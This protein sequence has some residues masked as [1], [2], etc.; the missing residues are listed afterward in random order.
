MPRRRLTVRDRAERAGGRLVAML[1]P[2]AVRRLAGPPIVR[3]GL[4]LDPQIQLV[5]KAFERAGIGAWSTLGPE[6]ARTEVR[7]TAMLS[8]LPIPEVR[9]LELTVPGPAGDL[10]ARRYDPPRAAAGPRPA[11][12][13]FHG[14][15]FVF[16][17][18]DTHDQ[19]CRLLCLHSGATVV[20]VEYR[21]A[22]EAPFP[23]AV[24]DAI[25]AFAW[26]HEHS[27]ELGLD[28]ERIAVGGDSAGGNL[29]AVVAQQ[30]VLAGDPAPAFQLLIYPAVD[31][32]HDTRSAE[33]FSAGFFLVE[34][35]MAWFGDSYA[36][37][38]GDVRGA[39]LLSEDLSGLAPAHIVTAG[40]DPLR[41]EGEAY[42][43][44]LAEAGV[45]VALRRHDGLVHGF[46]SMTS[47]SR[48]SRDAV[49]EMAGALRMGLAVSRA[50]ARYDGVLPPPGGASG[51]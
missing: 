38:P 15:G 5:L 26:V 33:L 17:D 20:A 46:A 2:R 50:E 40:F 31:H 29:S 39:P 11:L 13:F 18:L 16:G 24:E 3:D 4:T 14:G 21:L 36:A 1:P 32:E 8:A 43:A 30:T 28:P 12:L 23:C 47:V 45:P 10:P 7:R 37:A 9:A 22:P 34:E 49:I 6:G 42:A 44:A 41:D 35:D 27:G 25:A 48:T 51:L 19:L